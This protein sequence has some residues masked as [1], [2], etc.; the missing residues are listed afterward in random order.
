MSALG[1]KMPKD[2]TPMYS[3]TSVAFPTRDEPRKTYLIDSD[4][5]MYIPKI[6]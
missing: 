6:I 5:A 3:P 2:I 1:L 4:T